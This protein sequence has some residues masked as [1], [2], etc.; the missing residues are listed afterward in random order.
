MMATCHC[1]QF[2]GDCIV[3]EL[4]YQRQVRY[5]F[6]FA[7]NNMFHRGLVFPYYRL[8]KISENL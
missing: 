1:F 6:P 3:A 8:D 4:I 7:D 2:E 5:L